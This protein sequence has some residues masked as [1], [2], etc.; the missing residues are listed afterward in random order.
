MKK[1]YYYLEFKNCIA[2]LNNNIKNLFLVILILAA[3]FAAVNFFIGKNTVFEPVKVAVAIDENDK[4]TKM[5][6]RYISKE[7]SIKNIAAF[8]YT[9]KDDAFNKLSE[10]KVNVVIDFGPDFYNDVNNGKNTPLCVYIREDSDLLT[11]SF[12]NLLLSAEGYVKNTEATVYSFLKTANE[13]YVINEKGMH[14]GDYIALIYGNIILKRTR[15]YEN[16]IISPLGEVDLYMYIFTSALLCLILFMI[17]MFEGLYESSESSFGK[18]IKIYGISDTFQSLT[19]QS[20]ISIVIYIIS[21]IAYFTFLSVSNIRQM[22]ISI[23]PFYVLSVLIC[24]IGMTSLYNMIIYL[25]GNTAATKILIVFIYVIMTISSGIIIP[26][27]YLPKGFMYIGKIIPLYYN[28][29]LLLGNPNI[30]N[31][32]MSFVFILVENII[33]GAICKKRS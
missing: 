10:T 13:G 6:M 4:M 19:K 16:V 23:E 32:F 2:I 17:T 15:L 29:K 14:I 1:K 28:G 8:E 24:I 22:N 7:D 9:D 25:L 5:I 12:V 11:V 33:V 20:V 3:A 31:I 21:M 26:F 30:F 18:V 27:A